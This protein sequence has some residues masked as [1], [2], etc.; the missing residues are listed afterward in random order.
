MHRF[1]GWLDREK[2]DLDSGDFWALLVFKFRVC[3]LVLV[4]SMHGRPGRLGVMRSSR[5]R[6]LQFLS[7]FAKLMSGIFDEY[8]LDFHK[9]RHKMTTNQKPESDWG[10]R[11]ISRLLMNV[12][13]HV[14]PPPATY[15]ELDCHHLELV[16]YALGFDRRFGAY[17]ASSKCG[18]YSILPSCCCLAQPRIQKPLSRPF[19]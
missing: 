10:M 16:H 9:P 2:A 17:L 13:P 7:P 15:R 19:S 8:F 1:V 6:V 3:L 12:L 18:A 14:L 11:R 4:Q 5:R